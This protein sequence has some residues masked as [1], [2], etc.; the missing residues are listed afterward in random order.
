MLLTKTGSSNNEVTFSIRRCKGC[1]DGIIEMFKMNIDDKGSFENLLFLIM[2]DK[3]LKVDFK[4]L[5]VVCP[6][7]DERMKD[8]TFMQFT[9]KD[10][11]LLNE[12]PLSNV[13][14]SMTD[15]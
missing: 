11:K 14:V 10:L 4:D 5:K 15:A 8:I 3:D 2:Q 7:C 13:W 9:E 6:N 12:T 1:K